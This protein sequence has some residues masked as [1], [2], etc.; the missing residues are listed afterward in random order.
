M[1]MRGHAEPSGRTAGRG[2]PCP[3]HGQPDLLGGDGG[4]L[5]RL[6]PIAL[7]KNRPDKVPLASS[8]HLH[9]IYLSFSPPCRVSCEQR[10]HAHSKLLEERS[11]G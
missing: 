6:G 4:R 10:L 7:K 11:G 5:G 2:T 1:L 8:K 9:R 3:A